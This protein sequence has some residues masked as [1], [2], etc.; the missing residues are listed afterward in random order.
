MPLFLESLLTGIGLIASLDPEVFQ[1]VSTSLVVSLS[2]I[3]VAT[4]I[5]VPIG[6]AVAVTSF[7]GRSFLITVL[8][9][10][11]A[12][13]TVVVGLIIY[14]LISRGGPLG[15]L[16][17]LF[18]L[19]GMVIGQV[20]LA[21]PI[22]AAYTVTAVQDVD[23]R[24]RPTVLTLGADRW[25]AWWTILGE[26][27]FAMIAAVVAGFGRIVAE[28]GAAMILGGNIAGYTRN[29]TTAIAV[30]TSKG[31]FGL[32]LALGVIL[33]VVAFSVNAMFHY[34]QRRGTVGS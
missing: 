22:V 3:A 33:L 19:R 23:S 18:T 12:L 29:I 9:T 8:N 27:R 1:I 24:A 14:T 20:V 16:G 11:L 5:G 15:E 25:F 34:F 31:N 13:P 4:A 10:L 21:T 7:R 26:A 2:A 17:I 6:F 30:E 32:A 28:V